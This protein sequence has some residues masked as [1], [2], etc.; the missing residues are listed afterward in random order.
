MQDIPDTVK[1]GATRKKY[2][3][4]KAAFKIVQPHFVKYEDHIDV[5]NGFYVDR[6]PEGHFTIGACI[7]NRRLRNFGW[8]KA[9][10]DAAISEAMNKYLELKDP[11]ERDRA[12]R[13]IKKLLIAV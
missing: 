3:R 4:S 13:V 5:F 12:L 1:K 9:Y 2:P 10:D 6:T 8:E 7:L 11:L